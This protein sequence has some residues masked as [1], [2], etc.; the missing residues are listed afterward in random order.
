MEMQNEVDEIVTTQVFQLSTVH[1]SRRASFARLQ[2]W[3]M[4]NYPEAEEAMLQQYHIPGGCCAVSEH[5]RNWQ[6]SQP[7]R[8][9]EL[10]R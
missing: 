1:V 2:G 4:S 8:T 7:V 3:G 9:R 10:S 6:L 5:M